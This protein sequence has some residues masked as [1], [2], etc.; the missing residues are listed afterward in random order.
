MSPEP[1]GYGSASGL[2]ALISIAVLLSLL[3]TCLALA[4]SD[5]VTTL[6]GQDV[7]AS[8]EE[9][10]ELLPCQPVDPKLQP[11]MSTEGLEDFHGLRRVCRSKIT[12]EILTVEVAQIKPVVIARRRSSSAKAIALTFDD[13]PQPTYTTRILDILAEHHAQA[14]FFV[15]GIYAKKYPQII[16]RQIAEGHEVAIHSWAHGRYTQMSAAAMANDIARCEKLLRSIARAPV[17][18]NWFR[19]L[20]MPGCGWRCGQ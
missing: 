6:P 1:S 10:V 3:T 18:L 8:V 19:S 11:T 2:R 20:L 14:T 15:L 13:G 4:G 5:P 7:T 16:R 12:G 17:S 9:E